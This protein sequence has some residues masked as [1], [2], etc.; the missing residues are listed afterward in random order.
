[1][2]VPDILPESSK[3]PTESMRRRRAIENIKKHLVGAVLRIS[4]FME[5]HN[6]SEAIKKLHFAPTDIEMPHGETNRVRYY[7]LWDSSG[8]RILE[9]GQ[10]ARA[11]RDEPNFNDIIENGADRS[12]VVTIREL[13]MDR[14]KYNTARLADIGLRLENILAPKKEEARR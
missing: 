13:E 2:P 6:E 7:S 3:E 10:L 9:T 8:L 5:N 1:M 4:E 14:N 12:I 11:E